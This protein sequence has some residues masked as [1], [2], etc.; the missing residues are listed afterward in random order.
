MDRVAGKDIEILK[1]PEMTRIILFH[2]VNFAIEHIRMTMYSMIDD[3]GRVCAVASLRPVKRAHESVQKK[4]F[5]WLKH[6]FHIS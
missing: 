4:I 6:K 1:C 3:K 2:N 5:E